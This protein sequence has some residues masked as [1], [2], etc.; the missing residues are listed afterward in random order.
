[1]TKALMAPVSCRRR[2]PGAQKDNVCLSAKSSTHT[3][4]DGGSGL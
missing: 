2:R 4:D 1:M 3:V